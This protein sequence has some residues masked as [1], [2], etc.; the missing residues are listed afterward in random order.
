MAV[1]PDGVTVVT[2]SKDKSMRI[3]EKTQEPLVLEEEKDKVRYYFLPEIQQ[4]NV[5]N[6]SAFVLI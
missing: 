6:F 4:T 2:A 1:S 5:N 3:W